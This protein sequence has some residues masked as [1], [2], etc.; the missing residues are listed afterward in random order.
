MDRS[1]SIMTLAQSIMALARKFLDRSRSIMTL[2][3]SIMALARKFLALTRERTA[4]GVDFEPPRAN[5]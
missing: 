5:F 3:Q 1:R 4:L 2:A